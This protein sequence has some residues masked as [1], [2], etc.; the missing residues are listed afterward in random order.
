MPSVTL[1]AP[2]PESAADDDLKFL[3]GGGEM[4]A[5]MRAFPWDTTPI[6]APQTWPQSLRLS[7]R[8]LLNNSHPMFIWWG[9][10]LIQFYNNAYRQTMGPERHPSALGQRGRDCWEEIWPIIGP[11]IDMVMSGQGATWHEDALVP[12]TRHGK[13]ENVWWTYSYSP[14]DDE[15][16]PG[17]IGGVLVICHDVTKRKQA[18]DHRELLA[19]E[20]NHRVKNMMTTIQAIANQSLR[21]G[22]TL[23][24]GRDAF[25]GRLQALSAAQDILVGS[26]GLDVADLA[27][28][29]AIAIKP[30]AEDA[31]RFRV[32]GLPVRLGP[33]STLAVAIALHEL[34]TNA[35][36][37]GSLSKAGGSVEI[38][39]RIEPSASDG[40]QLVL[41]WIESG[42]PPVTEPTRKGFG[43]RLLGKGLADQ[44][45][46]EVKVSYTPTGLSYSFRAPLKFLET[47]F[48]TD[49]SP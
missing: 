16:Q 45:K 48:K 4:G 5:L 33:R 26:R 30:F 19:N 47:E 7:V 6:G 11:Q 23:Q 17:G 22:V 39:W 42:G 43:S 32:N 8:L 41:H 2:R 15:G 46:G 3:A 20:L 27:A 34:C 1:D 29:V 40:D 28:V 24:S 12:V 35:V 9:P 37:Y 21:D 18:E 13:R 25:S 14:I 36:K 44:L 31:T 49:L 10:E 38:S